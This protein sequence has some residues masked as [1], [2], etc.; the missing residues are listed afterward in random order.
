[1]EAAND[2]NEDKVSIMTLHAAKGLEFE[3]VFLPGWEEGLFPHQRS[4]DES[5]T[6]R[7]GRRAPPRLCRHYPRQTARHHQ[8]C[9]Q[10]PHARP[11]ELGFAV[12]LY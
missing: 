7:L 6:K 9:R 11:V 1:M 2:D 5:G 4:L 10:S 8:L 12:A 3:S